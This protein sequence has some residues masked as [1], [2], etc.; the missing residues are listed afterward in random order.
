MDAISLRV[1]TLNAWALPAP[2]GH[3]VSG[4]IE[5]LGAALPPLHLDVVALQEVWRGDARRLLVEAG[6]RSGLRYHWHRPRALSGSGLLVLSRWPILDAAFEGY[7]LG[8]P[9]HLT[10][11]D[12]FAGKGFARLRIAGPDG[13]FTLINTH[14][15]ARYGRRVDHGYSGHR[16]GQIVQLAK[17]MRGVRDP[18]LLVGDFNMREDHT[19]YAVLHGLTHVRDLSRERGRAEATVLP[20]N[21]YRNHD[22]PRRVDYIFARDGVETR[23]VPLAARRAFDAIFTLGGEPATYS[24][25]AG[26]IA[27]VALV[28][29]DGVVAPQ[30]DPQAVAAARQALRDGRERAARRRGSHRGGAVAAIGG[31]AVLA[32]GVRAPALGRRGFLRSALQGAAVA[33]TAPAAGLAVVSELVVPEELHAFD[34]LEYELARLERVEPLRR[35]PRDAVRSV[36]AEGPEG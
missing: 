25:H 24:D 9:P 21:P 27:D 31:A 6:R 4:R 16:A 8:G 35:S 19:G 20:E 17:T 12:Y 15:Q 36:S 22:T 3:Q 7:L 11:L 33:L 32:A 5:Q 26:V 1:A 34:L 2:I 29:G 14:L 23:W 18:L 10:R 13:P 30:V 28:A